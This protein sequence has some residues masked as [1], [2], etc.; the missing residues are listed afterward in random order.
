MGMGFL[1]R[2][3]TDFELVGIGLPMLDN[4]VGNG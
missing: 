1:V 3:L 4:M 2:G